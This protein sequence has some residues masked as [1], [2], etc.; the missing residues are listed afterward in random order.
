MYYINN[1]QE[2][3]FDQLIN[4]PTEPTKN[5]SPSKRWKPVPHHHLV[6]LV[7]DSVTS[8]G[9]N[10]HQERYGLDK[11]K[12]LFGIIK[13]ER[14]DHSNGTFRNVIGIRNSHNQ[15]FS[16]Q[17]VGGANV[18]VCDKRKHTTNIMRDLPEIVYSLTNDVVG[19]YANQKCRYNGYR[20]TSLEKEDVADIMY[21]AT[22]NDFAIAGGQYNKVIN[23][24]ENPQHDEFEPGNAWSLFNAFT[25]IYKG[26]NGADVRKSI[27]LHN[28]FDR[29]CNDAIEHE[30]TSYAP[31]QLSLAIAE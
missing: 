26:Y 13:L 21:D 16:A 2:K 24:Y 17:L 4:V 11:H 22:R 19:S 9:F 10:I 3:S 28:V 20:A 15:D 23:E 7:K 5:I 1:S 30:M 12:N 25:E 6:E 18:M 31:N 8:Q 27:N 29:H 14:E